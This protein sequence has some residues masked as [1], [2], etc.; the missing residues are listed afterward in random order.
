MLSF[1]SDI[2]DKNSPKIKLFLQK[3]AKFLSARGFALRPPKQHPLC[4]VL[5]TR[6]GIIL[7]KPGK[8]RYFEAKPIHMII[9]ITFFLLKWLERLILY[10]INENKYV[11]AKLS[12]TQYGFRAGVSTETALHEFV[13]RVEH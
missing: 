11:Q 9:T 7:P 12:A 4:E 10:H 2:F 5:A 1:K 13:H 3:N 6:L 8:V